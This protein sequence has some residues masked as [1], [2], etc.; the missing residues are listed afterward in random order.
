VGD[1]CGHRLPIQSFSP[2]D[3]HALESE[4]LRVA[5]DGLQVPFGFELDGVDSV[6]VQPDQRLLGSNLVFDVSSP[7]EPAIRTAVLFVHGDAAPDR[8]RGLKNRPLF[9]SWA[10]SSPQASTRRTDQASPR[11]ISLAGLD[12]LGSIQGAPARSRAWCSPSAHTPASRWARLRS[13]ILIT[14]AS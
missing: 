4:Y 10:A 11:P 3:A 9:T 13:L 14:C 1:D 5:H 12:V 7:P 8:L 6:T 2:A